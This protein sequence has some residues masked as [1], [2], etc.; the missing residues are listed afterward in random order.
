MKKILS[1]TFAIALCTGV[2]VFAE[3]DFPDEDPGAP[4]EELICDE[5]DIESS[6]L[7]E[8]IENTQCSCDDDPEALENCLRKRTRQGRIVSLLKA[9]LRAKIVARDFR[10][11]LRSAIDDAVVE[12][13]ESIEEDEDPVGDEEP[14]DD[15]LGDED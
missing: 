4:D 11:D 12:C 8:I 7:A 13:E 10:A 6:L 2:P 1:F 3:E 15:N 5:P 14:G 9:L